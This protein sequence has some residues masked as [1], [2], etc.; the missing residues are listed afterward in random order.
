MAGAAKKNTGG[1]ATRLLGQLVKIDSVNPFEGKSA[2]EAEIAEFIRKELDSY[3][4]DARLQKVRGR[5]SNAIGV[6]K[7][8]G[9]GKSLM[10]NGHIDTVGVEAMIVDPFGASIDSQGRLHGRGAS[11]MKGSLASMMAAI[12]TIVDSGTALAGDLIFTGVIDEEYL[13]IG[14]SAVIREYRADA[15]IVGEPTCLDVGLAHRGY[16]WAE[17]ETKGKASHG[18]VPEKGLDAIV[19]MGRLLSELPTLQESYKEILHPLLGSPKI[20]ASTIEGGTEWAVV[21]ESCRLHVERRTLPGESGDVL[22][23]ELQ[24]IVAK[25]SRNH[26]TFQATVKKFFEQEPMEVPRSERVV[27]SV[28]SAFKDVTGTRA[29][30]VGVPYWADAALLANGAKIPTCLFGPGDINL[31]HSADEYISV[32]EV[33]LGARI[34]T[35]AI[36][37]FCG[38]T[39]QPEA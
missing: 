2:G 22:I 34:F 37:D 17:V 38:T 24:E 21:P 18:S 12:K 16:V 13:S 7:G 11:D 28:T 25:L 30:F 39:K 32:D 35:R 29:R 4:L 23:E 27:R 10:L 1:Q 19:E 20:H 9:K 15:A 14:T 31:A 3:G 5:R 33:E 36:E 6:M 8:T 26:P